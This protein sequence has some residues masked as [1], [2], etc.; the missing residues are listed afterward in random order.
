MKEVKTVFKKLASDNFLEILGSYNPREIKSDKNEFF[1]LMHPN[2]S[3]VN[4]IFSL[5][6]RHK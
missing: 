2:S 1:D 4:K 3:R 6:L 5:N